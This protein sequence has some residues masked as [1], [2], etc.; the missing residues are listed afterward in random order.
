MKKGIVFDFDGV[1]TKRCAS[2]YHMYKWII[3]QV[4]DIHDVLAIEE[5]AQ[6]CLLWDQNGYCDKAFVLEKMKEA[7]FPNLNVSHWKQ[8]W[9][10]RF[11]EFQVLSDDVVPV[12]E[13]LH[14]QYR[15]AILSNGKSAS[16]HKKI[17]RTG[18]EK[19]FDAIIVGGDCEMEKPDP[20]IFQIACE[21]IGT[22]PS[23]TIMVGDTF[24][25]DISGAI[26]AGLQPIW[27]C[28]ERCG[29]TDFYNIPIVHNFKELENQ[30]LKYEDTI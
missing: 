19:Y 1:L 7:W 6:R 22:K 12:L 30:I 27:Y 29:I 15:L 17:H 9:Y 26:R 16:Q 10:E 14:T 8:V 18:L 3:E 28:Y 25:T 23:D 20:Q 13:N 24:F 4:G 11:D 2:A 21:K 5:M